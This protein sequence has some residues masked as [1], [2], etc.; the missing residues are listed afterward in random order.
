MHTQGY[1]NQEHYL[2][3][4]NIKDILLNEYANLEENYRPNGVSVGTYNT[5]VNFNES[6]ITPIH[7]WYGYKEGFS[8]SFVRDFV[9]KYATSSETV[10]FDPFG[11]VGT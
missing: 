4:S 6:L 3:M 1:Y 2:K 8:P 5:P 10:V 7:R 9:T 11:G